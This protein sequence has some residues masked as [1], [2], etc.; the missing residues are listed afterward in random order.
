R[1]Q[2]IHVGLAPGADVHRPGGVALERPQAHAGHVAD[3]DVVAGLLAVA[4][5]GHGLAAQHPAAEDRHHAGLA[6]RVLPWTVDVGIAEGD[7]GHAVLG[8][9]EV[10]VELARAFAH[11]IGADRPRRVRLRR[12]EGLLLTVRGPARR[13]EEHLADPGVPRRFEQRDGAEDVRAGVEGRVGD[14]AAHVHLRG[15]VVQDVRMLGA[16]QFGRLRVEDVELVEAR[17]RVQ[18]LTLAGAQ[19]VDH[20]HLVAGRQVGVDHVRADE[21]RAAGH[22]DLHAYTLSRKYPMVWPSPSSSPTFGSQPRIVR[23]RLMS[24]W[25]CFGSS[26]GSGRKTISLD[27][28]VSALMRSANWR[29]VTS[30]GLPQFTGPL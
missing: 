30:A 28:L 6:M 5:H 10:T 11:A 22:Q 2:L 21:A 25:R 18:V 1:S 7:E 15:V 9:V 24:G 13:H 27:D 14:G 3:V 19:V 20:E 23:A 17:L 29:I 12:G 4:V 16:D 8:L 26:T